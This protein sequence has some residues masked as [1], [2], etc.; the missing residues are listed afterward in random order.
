MVRQKICAGNWKMYKTPDEAREYFRLLPSFLKSTNA[1]LV[2]FP[3][4]YLLQELEAAAAALAR[5]SLVLEYGPQNIHFSK[6]GAFTGEIS[7]A[8]VRVMGADFALIGHSE[9]RTLF[10][11]TD[12]TIAKKVK[13]AVENRLTPM[14]CVGETLSE[15]DAGQTNSVCQRQLEKG[16]AEIDAKV[17]DFVIAYEPVWAIGT[18]R[19]ATP[20][21]ADEAHAAIR[22]ALVKIAGEDRAQS[23]PI[24]YGGS[25]K[26]ENAI[27]LSAKKNIDGFLIGGASLKPEDFAKI[28][29][30]L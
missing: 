12:D 19:V 3:P 17:T 9:R 29:S 1:R 30:S 16:L 27:G 15:R 24:L 14:L 2:I 8:A 5:A 28:A 11:E 4:A 23:T 18:G 20:D 21:Q 22:Q 25:V 7:P 13:A 26:P 10:F 6:E